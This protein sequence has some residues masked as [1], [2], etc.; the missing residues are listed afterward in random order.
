MSKALDRDTV[1]TIER[2]LDAMDSIV[3]AYRWHIRTSEEYRDVGDAECALRDARDVLRNRPPRHQKRDVP[4]GPFPDTSTCR[5]PSTY[6]LQC[7]FCADEEIG[8]E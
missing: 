2:A 6:P 7:D 4:D 1:R 3:Q 5:C 8:D